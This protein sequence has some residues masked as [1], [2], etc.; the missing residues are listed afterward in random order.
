M[1]SP[2]APPSALGSASRRTAPAPR[3]RHPQRQRPRRPLRRA[4]CQRLRQPP[5]LRVLRLDGRL[6]QSPVRP[7]LLPGQ[8]L[9]LREPS[10]P[11]SSSPAAIPSAPGVPSRIRSS[12]SPSPARI[13]SA[14]ACTFAASSSVTPPAGSPQ[15]HR[16]GIVSSLRAALR[17]LA[18]HQHR[19]LPGRPAATPGD[20]PRARRRRR[21]PRAARLSRSARVDPRSPSAARGA[22]VIGFLGLHAERAAT[23][24][25]P[26]AG[27]LVNV[28]QI[29]SSVP[30]TWSQN[31]D[32]TEV[33]PAP[34]TP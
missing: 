19:A 6:H 34:S 18:E 9:H 8:R 31:A 4:D 12:P 14:S 10:L 25:Q 16:D 3:P 29:G 30:S 32:A 24:A 13:S 7:L 26:D 15:R 33:R 5:L 23:G 27:P 17:A 2:S 28:I 1:A 20:P 22:L 11:A 21:S